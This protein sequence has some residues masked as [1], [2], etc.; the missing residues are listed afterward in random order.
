MHPEQNFDLLAYC[1][2]S[3][4][5]ST[6]V[7]T[8]LR[9]YMHHWNESATSALL[10]CKV[11]SEGRLAELLSSVFACEV[12]DYVD[13]HDVQTECL[14]RLDYSLARKHMMLPKSATE[15]EV[16]VYCADP[17]DH[18]GLQILRSIF[19]KSLRLIVAPR[20]EIQLA[21]SESY[22]SLRIFEVESHGTTRA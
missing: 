14:L 22:P 19:Q 7:A 12:V 13:L 15:S 10:S 5:V 3:G 8:L 20:T 2:E 18:D 16:V 21:I 4:E 9:Q 17:A 11:V 6:D 1:V